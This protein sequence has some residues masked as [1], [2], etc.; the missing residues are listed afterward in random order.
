MV[1]CAM[2]NVQLNNRLKAIKGSKDDFGGLSM[3][4][5]GDLFLL[6][7]VMDK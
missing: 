2:F 6:E 1:G 4:A 5:I 3:V 7:P